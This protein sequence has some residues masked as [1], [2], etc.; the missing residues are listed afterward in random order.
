MKCEVL[1]CHRVALNSFQL[2]YIFSYFTLSYKIKQGLDHIS[3]KA[4]KKSS[5]KFDQCAKPVSCLKRDTTL[6][7][8]WT[9]SGLDC[10]ESH[11]WGRGVVCLKPWRIFRFFHCIRDTDVRDSL[12]IT[13]SNFGGYGVQ[14]YPLASTAEL[15]CCQTSVWLKELSITAL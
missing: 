1:Q 7:S 14:C 12:E 13:A 3:Q 2:N 5:L 11:D 8:M 10:S 6:L 15:W 4:K 9:Y